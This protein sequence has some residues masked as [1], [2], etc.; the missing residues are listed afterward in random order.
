[1]NI[2]IVTEYPGWFLIFCILAGMAYAWA[3][4]RKEKRL[5][6]AP[7]WMLW[8]FPIARFLTV[9]ILC[10][11]LLGPLIKNIHESRERPIVVMV[12]D[13]SSSLTM[14]VDSAYYN[15]TFL[16]AYRKVADDLASDYD[17]RTFIFDDQARE[18]LN[19]T[20]KGVQ[21]DMSE[22]FR[23]LDDRFDHRNVGA[24]VIASDGLVNKGMNPLYSG[25]RLHAPMYTVAL[26][27]TIT[28]KDLLI[29][30]V[31]FNHLA[32]FGND[33]PLEVVV[34]AR[35]CS[36]ESFRLTITRDGKEL[37]GTNLN[38]SNEETTIPVT[39]TLP[40]DLIGVN[41]LRLKLT[42]LKDEITYENNTTDV[43]IDV[44]DSR[45]RILI[46]GQS[47]H[48]DMAALKSS[49]EKNDQY[50]VSVHL[51]K[52][53]AGGTM[54][55]AGNIPVT[56]AS[57]VILHNLPSS[58]P[59]AGRMN[60]LIDQVTTQGIPQWYIVGN[61]TNVNAFNKLNKGIEIAPKGQDGT[62]VSGEWSSSFSLFTSVDALIS[63][64][65]IF[66]P[67][68]AP[69]GD[70]VATEQIH[71]AMHQRV[72]N[73]VTKVPLFYFH[74]ANDN[75]AAVLTGEG[76]WRWR[77]REFAE[78]G[79]QSF[80]D[81]WISK[82]V[83]YLAVKKDRSLFRV[84]SKHRFSENEY[85]TL[86]AELYNKAYELINNPD[87][88]IDIKGPDEKTYSYVFSRTSDAYR[89]NAGLLPSGKYTYHA[90]VSHAGK[91][92]TSDGVFTITSV[93][94]EGLRTEADHGLLYALA[95]ESG[96][97]LIAPAQVS[98]LPDMIRNRDDIASVVIQD[99]KLDDLISKPWL[100]ALI[101]LL[102]TLEWFA[103][104][105]SGVY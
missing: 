64:M 45:Q 35:K 56:K 14:T 54:L 74:E 7:R 76:I 67:L 18:G 9:T 37:F 90:R 70:Y 41:H 77:L 103:R 84:K 19:P 51:L 43:F 72:G 27:D 75:K 62:Q 2:N 100:L 102:L 87:V 36:G 78:F 93:M 68:T 86:D 1:M 52:D 94:A 29:K 49:L 26:G 20:F 85:I 17:V 58:T 22:L 71:I 50:E 99:K 44:I 32:F 28:R 42:S 21:T 46:I 5:E 97:G 12:M 13:N 59:D 30:K 15:Q 96:G 98:K 4:Y 105:R 66:P 6:D 81:T 39:L 40:A 80:F 57:L 95:R 34:M 38:A 24:V 55:M 60:T 3:L 65:N 61:Q 25:R 88:K 33:F 8:L 83:Q 11:F 73:V 101:I 69:F 104:K 63:R 16:P 53:L 10:F 79:D 47:P 48:P 92:H 23:E 31:N 82:T 89:L 91:T